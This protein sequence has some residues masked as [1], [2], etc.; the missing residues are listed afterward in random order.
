MTYRINCKRTLLM[1]SVLRWLVASWLLCACIGARAAHIDSDTYPYLAEITLELLAQ[2]KRY[3]AD[4]SKQ[5]LYNETTTTRIVLY[6]F[7]GSGI[8]STQ[9]FP[10]DDDPHGP[11]GDVGLMVHEA[12][13]NR[14]GPSTLEVFDKQG[15]ATLRLIQNTELVYK[16][17]KRLRDV[18]Y[19]VELPIRFW[20]GSIKDFQ[21]RTRAT[22]ELLD[23]GDQ[24]FLKALTGMVDRMVLERRKEIDENLAQNGLQLIEGTLRYDIQSIGPRK[25]KIVFE[26]N[27][28]QVRL[29]LPDMRI[30]IRAKVEQSYGEDNDNATQ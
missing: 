3:G 4:A 17:G 8:L 25:L 1:A 5:D 12:G 28:N 18:N 21:K 19:S 29:R 11:L 16:S 9:N 10:K 2:E 13:V 30:T 7:W 27:L 23:G 15:Q 6:M 22:A 14:A 26:N 20:K 24:I